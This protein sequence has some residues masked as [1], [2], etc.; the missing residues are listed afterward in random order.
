MQVSGHVL[1]EFFMPVD[2]VPLTS[3]YDILLSLC[4][5]KKLRHFS[6]WIFHFFTDRQTSYSYTDPLKVVPEGSMV[7]YLSVGF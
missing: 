4:E 3:V 1:T 7:E 6:P 5:M 2:L